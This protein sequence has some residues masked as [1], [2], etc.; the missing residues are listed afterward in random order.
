[1]SCCM[2]TA[3]Y[4]PPELA[5]IIG[6]RPKLIGDLLRA[7]APLTACDVEAMIL[8][9]RNRAPASASNPPHKERANAAVHHGPVAV[10]D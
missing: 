8:I 4:T 6:D 7:V 2:T 10:A 3:G 9:A 1:M 5:L